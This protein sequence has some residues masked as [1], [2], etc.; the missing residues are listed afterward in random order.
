MYFDNAATTKP[1]KEVIADV[2]WCLENIWGNPSSI[3]TPG[4]EARKI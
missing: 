2:T 4:I 3:H 1:T